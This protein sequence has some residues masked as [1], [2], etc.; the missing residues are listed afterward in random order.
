MFLLQVVNAK[1]NC[2]RLF[3]HAFLFMFAYMVLK[4]IVYSV[5]ATCIHINFHHAY[6]CHDVL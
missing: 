2:N 3:L 4:K 1:L 6:Y 5:K